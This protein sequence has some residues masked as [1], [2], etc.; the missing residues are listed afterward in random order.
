MKQWEILM[1]QNPN[2]LGRNILDNKGHWWWK[3]WSWNILGNK[4]NWCKRWG[5]GIWQIMQL[6]KD[7]TTIPTILRKIFRE[8]LFDFLQSPTKISAIK[9]WLILKE[10]NLWSF[11]GRLITLKSLLSRETSN[12]D[13][14][15]YWV[16]FSTNFWENW[17]ERYTPAYF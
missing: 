15:R 17:N 3:N 10:C 11:C 13:M 1:M 9:I 16:M 2:I 14:P 5:R 8:L 4:D 12:E 6:W 7:N